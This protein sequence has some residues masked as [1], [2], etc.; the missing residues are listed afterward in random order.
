M[1]NTYIGIDPSKHMGIVALNGKEHYHEAIH[2]TTFD[3][4]KTNPFNLLTYLGAL[5]HSSQGGEGDTVYVGVEKP[6]FSRSPKGYTILYSQAKR[7]GIIQL[8]CLMYGAEYHEVPVVTWKRIIVGKGTASKADVVAHVQ[9]KMGITYP[10]GTPQDAY[11]AACVA[12]WMKRTV[13]E[14][15]E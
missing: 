14:G 10:T 2:D 12:E 1:T 9:L 3:G 4:R 13:E 15:V 8:A 5:I 11:D 7:N 6:P